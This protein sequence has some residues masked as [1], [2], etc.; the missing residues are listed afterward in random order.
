MV[1]IG[2]SFKN[3]IC[4]ATY[5]RFFFKCHF[6]GANPQRRGLFMKHFRR[7]YRNSI[8]FQFYIRL[9]FLFF[10]KYYFFEDVEIVFI[11]FHSMRSVHNNVHSLLFIL[12]FHYDYNQNNMT[13]FKKT[14]LGTE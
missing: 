3:T 14:I 7:L 4:S 9:M 10:F 8:A 11:Q 12:F 1:N 2:I 13:L 6:Y 5:S